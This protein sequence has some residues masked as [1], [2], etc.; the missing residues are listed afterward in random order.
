MNPIKLLSR[1]GALTVVWFIVAGCGDRKA[2]SDGA[3]GVTQFDE[4]KSLF[5]A[6]YNADQ[7]VLYEGLPHQRNEAIL[8]KQEEQRKDTATLHSFLFYR[9]PLEISAEDKVKLKGLLGEA[10][11]FEPWRGEKKCGGFHPDYLAEWRV[12]DTIYR[13]L[14]CFG[15]HEVKVYGPDKS[16]RCD[17]RGEACKQLEELLKKH[18]KNRPPSEDP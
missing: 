11:S 12:G 7:L 16:L 1:W 6:I 17:I 15:C 2:D 5:A 9:A 4:N 13:F 18:R 8:F 14:I 10:E 3:E